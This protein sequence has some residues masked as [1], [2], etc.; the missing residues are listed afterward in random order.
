MKN[1]VG[2]GRHGCWC[3][4][5]VC[6]IH[7]QLWLLALPT[8]ASTFCIFTVFFPLWPHIDALYLLYCI[9]Q[10]AHSAMWWKTKLKA[11]MLTDLPLL[12]HFDIQVNTTIPWTEN[13][14]SF[15]T[16]L[17]RLFLYPP[18]TQLLFSLS[19]LQNSPLTISNTPSFSFLSRSHVCE[20]AYTCVSAQCF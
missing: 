10:N 15:Q 14:S 7:S 2:S 12:T 8:E 20:H 3:L 1:T 16:S 6:L 18:V 13:R 5:N 17:L 19:I 4:I 9:L 11:I